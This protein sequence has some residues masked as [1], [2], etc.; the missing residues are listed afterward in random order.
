LESKTGFKI[1]VGPDFFFLWLA[2]K[3]DVAP[4][5]TLLKVE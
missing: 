1:P 3:I 2:N 5:G 4:Q